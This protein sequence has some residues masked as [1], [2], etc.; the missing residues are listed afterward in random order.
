[1][2]LEK[3]NN[4]PWRRAERRRLAAER[5]LE[6]LAPEVVAA[7][8]AR[9]AE[10]AAQRAVSSSAASERRQKRAEDKARAAEALKLAKRSLRADL[11]GKKKA[12]PKTVRAFGHVA[13]SA[14]A[15]SRHELHGSGASRRPAHFTCSCEN[16]GSRE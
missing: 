14:Q 4:A 11:R 12:A 3:T 2:R 16:L 10:R 8:A 7:R 13:A 15:V 6:K 9:K 1:V 5:R